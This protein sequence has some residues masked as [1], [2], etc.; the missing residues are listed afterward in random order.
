MKHPNNNETRH[1]NYKQHPADID[2]IFRLYDTASAY[3]K[4]KCCSL[5]FERQLVRNRTV[6][7]MEIDY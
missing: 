7:P 1:E 6:P 5:G 4:P 2:E 3:Q